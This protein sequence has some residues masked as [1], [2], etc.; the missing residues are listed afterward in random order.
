MREFRYRIVDP[1]TGQPATGDLK[2]ADKASA[3]E[4]LVEKNFEVLNVVEIKPPTKVEDLIAMRRPVPL[5]C[6]VYFTRQLATLLNA[7]MPL[8]EALGALGDSEANPKLRQAVQGIQNTVKGGTKLDDAFRKHPDIFDDRY[9]SMVSAGEVAGD[10]PG[11]LK[12]LANDLDKRA[13]MVKSIKSA[14]TYPKGIGIVA[15]LILSGLM[16]F[17]VPKFAD[18]FK[19]TAETTCG[20]GKECSSEL[21]GLTQAV[22]S[23]ASLLYPP[24]EASPLWLLSVGGRLIAFIVVIMIIRWVIRKILQQEGPRERWDAYKLRAPF[25]IGPLIQ[26]IAMARMART[27]TSLTRSGITPLEA[28]PIA[29]DSSGN[30]IVKHQLMKARDEMLKGKPL[31][32]TL[33]QSDAF[34]PLMVSMIKSGESVGKTEDMMARIADDYEDDVDLAIKGLSSIIEPMML[35]GVGGAI[36]I[37]VMSI[38]LPMFKMYDNIGFIVAP[39]SNMLESVL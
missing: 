16:I 14:T 8:L 13:K 33:E 19:Q 17:M 32:K 12:E 11:A 5:T 20:A 26:K 1:E 34:P 25:K 37:V 30:V 31:Y 27:F 10:T 3:E 23:V 6:L 4:Y 15:F 2:A 9:V 38:Y 7:E 35:V 28:L 36:G 21:P 29:A 22:Q 24:F 18:I 39:I